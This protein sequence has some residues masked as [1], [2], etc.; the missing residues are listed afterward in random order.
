MK[1]NFIIQAWL[2]IV[3]AIIFGAG[4]AGIQLTLSEKIEANKVAETL[5]QVPSLVPGSQAGEKAEI[6][7][8]I[9]YKAMSDGQQMGWVIPASGQ[10]FADI[11]EI[12]IGVNTDVSQITGMYVISQKETPGLG[13]FIVEDSWRGQ[14]AG[15][16]ALQP[17]LVTKGNPSGNEIK[18]LTGATISSESVC[19]IVNSTIALMRDKLKG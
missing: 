6:A 14:F 9:V 15:K 13:N 3:L 18:A 16:D 8:Q 17:V 11:I 19:N 4:L 2:V 12:L 10:G 5:L 7:G 1:N